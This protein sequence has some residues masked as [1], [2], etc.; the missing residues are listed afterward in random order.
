MGDIGD[1]LLKVSSYTSGD[2]V[3]MKLIVGFVLFRTSRSL[4]RNTVLL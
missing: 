3:D 4:K 1:S 2:W